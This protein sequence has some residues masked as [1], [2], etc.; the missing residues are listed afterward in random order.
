MTARVSSTSSASRR[1]RLAP[2]AAPRSTVLAMLPV[3]VIPLP[4]IPLP[5]IPFAAAQSATTASAPA[6][7]SSPASSPCLTARRLRIRPEIP[8]LVSRPPSYGAVG[9]PVPM[10][11]T[12]L[13]RNCGTGAIRRLDLKRRPRDEEQ[14]GHRQQA[15]PCNVLGVPRALRDPGEE[16][17]P[18]P[19]RPEPLKVAGEFG[20]EPRVVQV[21]LAARRPGRVPGALPAIGEDGGD[22][23]GG[24]ALGEPGEPGHVPPVHA[25]TVQRDQQRRWRLAG[26][27]GCP[28]KPVR[29]PTPATSIL[30]G[31]ARRRR[32]LPCEKSR[33][34]RARAGDISEFVRT[35]WGVG[36]LARMPVRLSSDFPGLTS[37]NFCIR[38]NNSSVADLI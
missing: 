36:R 31:Q 30:P 16:D 3:T 8:R 22:P 32:V 38:T 1:G 23:G 7:M 24:T 28:G 29:P 34:P 11:R 10:T 14:A 25:G 26:L 2:P 19:G 21:G 5:V 33:Y 4:L 18:R 9:S 17:R 27:P 6:T 13:A 15:V 35:R 37:L 12:M 20:E